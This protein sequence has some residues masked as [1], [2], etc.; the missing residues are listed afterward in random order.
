MPVPASLRVV[1]L[2]ALLTPVFAQVRWTPDFAEAM[3]RAK[4]EN[5]VVLFAFNLAGERANDEMVADHYKDPTLGKLS[6]ATVNVFCSIASEPRVPGVTPA[7]QQAAEQQARLQVLKIGPGE[8]VIAPQHVF[9]GPDG[10]VLSSVPWRLTKGELEWAW[11]DAIRKVDPAFAWQPSLGARAPG[12][13]SLGAV[14]RGENRKPPS[15]AEVDEALKAVK[16]SRG[17]MLRNLGH[18]ET[19]MRSDEPEAV[20]FV[21]TTV[22]GLQEAWLGGALDSMGLISPKAHHGTIVGHLADKDEAVRLA[23]AGALERMAEPKA[24]AALLKQ[25]KAE[26]ADAVRGRLLRAMASCGP[27]QKETLAQIDKL[28]GK[29]PN[30]DVRAQA[31]LALAQVEDKAKVHQ[32]LRAALRDPA[33]KVRATVAFAIAQRRD[34][35]LEKDLDDAA[36]RESELD[37]KAWLEAAAKVVRGGDGTPFKNFLE[38]ELGEKVPA[39]GLGGAG[40]RPGG[41]G[42][43]SGRGGPGGG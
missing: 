7:Q 9:V 34:V 31:V 40:G 26:K 12:K 35:E 37:T 14:E 15:K 28:M 39:A 32:G 8:D 4:A 17:A 25:Y 43:G 11:V 27:S 2:L 30:A 33:P 19:L 18:V 23:A 21:A 38:R 22:N 24:Y 5:K 10:T 6:Q 1:P 13:L 36:L 20:A 3:Q 29:E 16:K 42:G 41:G